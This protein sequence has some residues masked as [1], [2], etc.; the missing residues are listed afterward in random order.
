MLP[1][2]GEEKG[3]ARNMIEPPTHLSRERSDS[4]WIAPRSR[5]GFPAV[6]GIQS[7]AL[8]TRRI[9]RGTKRA[10]IAPNQRI[11]SPMCQEEKNTRCAI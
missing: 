3:V 11:M 1:K 7:T 4:G 2:G 8:P 5:R 9:I 6:V 10:D